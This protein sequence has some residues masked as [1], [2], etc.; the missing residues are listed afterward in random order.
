MIDGVLEKDDHLFTDSYYTSFQLYSDL[1]KIGIR[2]TGTV[3]ID[4]LSLEK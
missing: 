3:R 4:R 2:A 1:K